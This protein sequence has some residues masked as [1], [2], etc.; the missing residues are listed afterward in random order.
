MTDDMDFGR[1]DRSAH[2][3]CYGDCSMIMMAGDDEEPE[4]QEAYTNMEGSLFWGKL[5][6]CPP[7]RPGLGQQGCGNAE[8][9]YW[10]LLLATNVPSSL[11]MV[12]TYDTTVIA[13]AFWHLL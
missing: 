12:T 13:S 10:T 1:K 6:H 4:E 5:G 11:T 7:T 3:C 8:S 9:G 2:C